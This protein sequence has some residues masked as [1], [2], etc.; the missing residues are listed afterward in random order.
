MKAYWCATCGPG[1]FGDALTPALLAAFGIP[2]EWS[3]VAQADLVMVGS[4]LSKVPSGWGGIVL[5]TGTIRAGMRPNLPHAKIL[6]LRGDMTRRASGIR[7]TIPLGD[8]G[9]L[10]PVLLPERP[11]PEHDLVLVPH[12][13]DDRL[14]R[15]YR[16]V[17]V[18][19]IRQP[20]ERFLRELAKARTVATSSLHAMI[21]ADALG[22]PHAWHQHPKVIGGTWKFLDYASAFDALLRPGVERLTDRRRMAARQEQIAALIRSLAPIDEPGVMRI[23]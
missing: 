7:R 23:I 22:I 19:D 14:V 3:R 1:N 21:A 8:P 4:V 12:Y 18:L 10:A 13:V 11:E 9:I 17:P 6:A 16:G 20:P 5:G 2:C 15:R